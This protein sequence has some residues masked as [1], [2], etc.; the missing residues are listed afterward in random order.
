MDESNVKPIRSR[1][2]K[3]SKKVG[4]NAVMKVVAIKTFPEYCIKGTK[5]IRDEKSMVSFRYNFQY[6]Q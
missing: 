4:C 5:N 3:P 6:D 2:R 1:Q